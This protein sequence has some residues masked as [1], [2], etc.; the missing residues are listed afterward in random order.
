MDTLYI[1]AGLGF[2]IGYGTGV[3]NTLWKTKRKVV[4]RIVTGSNS[5]R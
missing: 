5:S 1:V 2:I 3:V 4:E